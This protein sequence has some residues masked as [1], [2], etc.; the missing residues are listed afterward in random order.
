MRPAVAAQDGRTVGASLDAQTQGRERRAEAHHR[1]E[2][3]VGGRPWA[4]GVRRRAP[5]RRRALEAV[6]QIARAAGAERRSQLVAQGFGASV[7]DEKLY[8]EVPDAKKLKSIRCANGRVLHFT[9]DSL[10]WAA[11][12]IYGELN[13]A[14][15]EQTAAFMWT[16]ARRSCWFPDIGGW[17][18]TKIITVY[19]ESLNPYWGPGAQGCKDYP[20]RRICGEQ[21]QKHWETSRAFAW[22]KAPL[23]WRK[24]IV[25]FATGE[26]VEDPVPD[27]IGWFL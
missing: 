17:S 5:F 13:T 26:K 3:E 8:A 7:P 25:R 16:I 19:N 11:R 20:K 24:T 6:R 12:M 9:Q 22:S 23:A 18:L 21:G 1:G 2:L 14:N 15:E 4:G 10:R 27:A